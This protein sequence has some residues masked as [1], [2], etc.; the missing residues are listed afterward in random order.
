MRQ[1]DE[2]LYFLGKLCRNGHDYEGTG[3]SL[4]Y[5]SRKKCVICEKSLLRSPDRWMPIKEALPKGMKRCARCAEIKSLESFSPNKKSADG[6]QPS[7]KA[8]VAKAR[9]EERRQSPNRNRETDKLWRKTHREH[10]RNYGRVYSI[11][12]RTTEKSLPYQFS[13]A[14]KQRMMDYFGH[15]CAACGRSAGLWLIIAIDHW[16]PISS[17]NCPGTVTTNLIPLCHAT[18][19]GEGGCNGRKKNRDPKQW[20]V[21]QFG[22]RRAREILKRIEAYFEWVKQFED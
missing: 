3:M 13:Q 12:R 17:S 19:D 4:R 18:R 21:E 11:K 22:K 20:I 14:A 10:L 6:R 7:C 9:R 15:K 5:V 8:C 16:I 1:F 2:R